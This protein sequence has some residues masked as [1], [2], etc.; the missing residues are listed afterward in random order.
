MVIQVGGIAA[1]IS[2]RYVCAGLDEPLEKPGVS[3]PR[4]APVGRVATG[5]QARVESCRMCAGLQLPTSAAAVAG[6]QATTKDLE[7][8]H[9][10]STRVLVSQHTAS[11]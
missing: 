6:F 5:Q 9:A 8:G 11:P 7:L 3:I 4:S 10:T 2:S 1:S